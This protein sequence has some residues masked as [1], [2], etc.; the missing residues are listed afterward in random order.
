MNRFLLLLLLAAAAFGQPAI[1]R[2][3]AFISSVGGPTGP[4]GPLR[5]GGPAITARAPLAPNGFTLQIS[6]SGFNEGFVVDWVD[7]NNPA[8]NT[9]FQPAQLSTSSITVNVAPPSL[10]A[11]ATAITI[12]VR[13]ISNNPV[14]ATSPFTVNP[15]LS[16]FEGTVML[17]NGSVNSPYSQPIFT[18]GTPPYTILLESGPTPPGMPTYNPQVNQNNNLY[19]G[20]P[21]AVGTF[22]FSLTINDPWG[23]NTFLSYRLQIATALAITNPPLPNGNVNVPYSANLTA[24]NGSPPYTWTA[25]GVPPG[26][27]LNTATGA[28]TGTPTTP[29]SFDIVVQV[30]DFAEA[31]AS[32]QYIVNIAAPIPP[33]L[34]VATSSPLPS[35]TVGVSYVYPFGATGGTGSYTWRLLGGSTPPG[36]S[37]SGTGFISGT[38]TTPGQFGFTVQVTDS[39]GQTAAKDFS[40]SVVPAPLVITTASPLAPAPMGV[41]L[42]IKF[43]ATGG[44][45]PYV[46]GVSGSL[47]PGTSLASDG[48]LSGTPA[49]TGTFTFRVSVTDSSR[50][51]SAPG[52][53]FKDFS[54]TI[55][56]PSLTI[57]TTSPLANGQ[58]GVSYSAQFAAAGGAPPYTWSGSGAPAG[59]SFSTGGLLSGTPTATGQSSLSVTVT[60][61]AGAKASGTFAITVIPAALAITTASLPNG[62]VGTA[63]SASLAASGG[64]PPYAWSA[65]G[66]PDGVSAAANGAISGTPTTAGQYKV[67]VT[68]KDSAGATAQQSYT[69][70]IALPPLT[71]TTASLPNGT[72]GVAY[73]ASLAASGGVTPYQWSATGLPA[74]LTLSSGGALAG[75]P[76]G[77]GTPS[78]AVTVKDSAGTTASRT[79]QVTIA[80]PPSPPVTFSGLSGTSNPG[81]QS[82]LQIGFGTSYPVDVTVVLTMVFKPDSGADDPAVQFSTG[83]RT[84]RILVPAGSTTGQTTVGVQNGTVAG[85]ITITTQLLAPGQDITPTP[86]PSET[87]RIA[88]TAPVISSITATRNST[89]FTVVI[90]G[91]ASS[92]DLTQAAFQFTATTGT[93]LQ[94]SSLTVPIDTIFNPWYASA[95]SAPYGSQFTFT[96]PFTVQGNPQSVVSVTVTMTSKVG[97]SAPATANLQ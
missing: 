48:T 84:A 43:A 16:Q 91:Y 78:I 31:S 86:A 52:T 68:V 41:P 7:N 66:L 73:S 37:I 30:T 89:G 20:T 61:S 46:F 19:A 6:G 90:V 74:G 28:I 24:A 65:G 15:P 77:A 93:N 81:T 69:V 10:Y 88:A 35:G 97:T 9:T 57:S 3:D 38:P 95:A 49:A 50:N 34:F 40:M 75:T 26:L 96:Q 12:R 82:Q 59:L 1:T 56:V 92:R 51:T 64:A 85:T 70:T 13:S 80:L 54:I 76:T 33:P 22:N 63:Y 8:N 94:T 72:V 18:G 58:V 25:S 44:V 79:F 27:T 42:S 23:A 11:V 2:L 71:I 17:P 60:D 29:G 14:S 55:T 62:N 21:T 39:S 4:T 47:P 83:G 5:P 45:P 53:A 87:I 67:A 32:T 36:L